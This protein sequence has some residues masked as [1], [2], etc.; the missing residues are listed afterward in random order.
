MEATLQSVVDLLAPTFADVATLWMAGD[1]GHL[2]RFAVAPAEAFETHRESPDI[3]CPTTIGEAHPICRVF[4]QAYAERLDDVLEWAEREGSPAYLE[5]VRRLGVQTAFLIPV[6]SLG[7]TIGVLDL[8]MTASGRKFR[9]FDPEVLEALGR[10]AGLAIENGRLFEAADRTRR[11]AEEAT[12][13]KD[14]FLATVSHELRNPLNSIIGWVAIMRSALARGDM[15]GKGLDTIERNARAQAQLIE[16]LLDVSR[17]VAGK[18]KV[19]PASVFVPSTIEAALD[20][21]RPAAEAKQIR[22]E[23]D[24]DPD[25]GSLIADPERLQQVIW[26]LVANAIKFT[27]PGGVVRVSAHRAKSQLE[28]S[29]ADTGKGI[30]H[31]FLPYVF[32]RFRQAE[33]GSHKS[34]GLGLGLAIVRHIV[35]LHG[36]RVFAES[37][38]LGKGAKFTVK[39]PIRAMLPPAGDGEGG[40]GSFDMSLPPRA[41]RG[42]KVLVVDDEEDARHLL[43]AMLE[44]AGAEVLAAGS[45]DEA[46]SVFAS[47]APD[48]VVTDI[49]MPEKDG[50]VLVREIRQ[51]EGR[52]RLP[53]IALTAYARS[54]DRTR[55][56]TAGFSTHIPKPVEPGASSLACSRVEG[57]RRMT[58]SHGFGVVFDRSPNAYMVL[59]RRLCYV[60]ANEAYLRLTASRLEDLLGRNIFDLFPHDPSDPSN[61]SARLLRESFERVI[62][63]GSP[64]AIALIPYRVPQL[65]ED[66]RVVA[67]ERLWRAVHTPLHD[68][69]GEVQFILQY[70]VDVTSERRLAAELEELAKSERS[71]RAEAERASR[72][73]DEFLATVSHELRTPLNAMLG[74]VRLL[75][76]GQVPPDKQASA[77]ETVERNARVQSQVIDDLLDVSRIMSGKL[78][79][80]RSRVRVADVV[81]AALDAVRPAAEARGVHLDEALDAEAS[82]SGDEDRLQQIVWNLASNAVKFSAANGRVEVRAQRSG[83]NVEITVADTGA[84]IAPEFLPRVFDRFSQADG[85]TTRSH[86]GLGLGLSIVKHLV[87]LHGGAVSAASEGLGRG[88]RFTVTLPSIAPERA[89]DADDADTKPFDGAKAAPRDAPPQASLKGLRVLVVDDERDAREVVRA[90]LEAR[91]ALVE[92]AP[93]AAEGF[94]AFRRSR[95]DVLL[96]DIAM[97]GGDGYSLIRRVRALPP[98]EGGRVPAIA[99]T[100]QARAAD[101]TRALMAGFRAHVPKPIEPSELVAV[102]ASIVP[103]AAPAET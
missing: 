23:I 13:A 50:Y 8:G 2:R 36:G 57:R 16:D 85:S 77:L 47:G 61:E 97:P 31:D 35:E 94:A 73:K 66:G 67:L 1:D 64:D 76:S 11:G 69:R 53:V 30:S 10:Q 28:L 101:R 83:P 81:K 22:L 37:E 79:V 26:N 14:Q 98:E 90:I 70:T 78:R 82:V 33:Q 68:D 96:S 3:P 71:A 56:L 55:A 91:G 18:L 102:L 42:A 72:L 52:A 5:D 87:E 17:I 15:L 45:V 9:E 51:R 80:K 54:E 19:H 6:R 86:G 63:T 32:E 46:L 20:S 4:E 39:I 21:A 44:Q 25:V 48:A 93:S 74:W 95:P 59:D 88:A 103:T 40:E 100:A 34:G 92:A 24:V 38:G 99:L 7:R 49:G 29:V 62:A 89:Q 12:L 58:T 43:V 60:A 75:R 84:G 41:L 65:I 27:P